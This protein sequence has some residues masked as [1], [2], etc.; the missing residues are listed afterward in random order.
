V[1]DH[2]AGV[3]ELTRH[4]VRAE[5]IREGF[6]QRERRAREEELDEFL[7]IQLRDIRVL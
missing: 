2:P 3:S 5:P 6:T 4:A 1:P 7:E